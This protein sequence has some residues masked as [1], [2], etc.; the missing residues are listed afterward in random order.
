[1][2]RKLKIGALVLGLTSALVLAGLV[3]RV[4]A[5]GSPC[6]PRHLAS[7]ATE[8]P[9]VSGP[10]VGPAAEQLNLWDL[11]ARGSAGPRSLGDPTWKTLRN[12]GYRYTLSVPTAW[13]V[14]IPRELNRDRA[15]VASPPGR[16]DIRFIVCPFGV[17]DRPLEPEARRIFDGLL[18][19]GHDRGSVS[20]PQSRWIR[21]GGRRGLVLWRRFAF[22]GR[23]GDLQIVATYVAARPKCFAL[24]L[25][26][27]EEDIQEVLPV[28]QRIV[29]SFRHASPEEQAAR[30]PARRGRV[31]AATP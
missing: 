30:T 22:E 21:V 25:L 2:G 27:P 7:T 3:L 17:Y 23:P 12:E 4:Q 15:R 13:D 8:A 18:P 16:P 10:G 20:P 14:A 29:Q 1:M 5:P 24:V 26:T 19:A 11:K 31:G 9:E 6:P 28:Y